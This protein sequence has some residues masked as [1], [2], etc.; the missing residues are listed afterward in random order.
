MARLTLPTQSSNNWC[1]PGFN[2]AREILGLD[3]DENGDKLMVISGARITLLEDIEDL[4]AK[5]ANPPPPFNPMGQAGRLVRV[6]PLLTDR[7]PP[8][9]RPR[10]VAP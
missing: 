6:R 8:I 3:P 9:H 1:R 10:T 2:E 5:N 7:A 4:S